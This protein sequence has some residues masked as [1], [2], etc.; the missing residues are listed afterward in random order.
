VASHWAARGLLVSSGAVLRG[1]EIWAV[2]AIVSWL[3]SVAILTLTVFSETFVG[4][5]CS[6]AMRVHD[7]NELEA[8]R[9]SC[10]MSFSV[11]L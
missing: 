2:S 1:V 3:G 9:G 4:S 6:G 8:R 11:M 10:S 7:L 5:G